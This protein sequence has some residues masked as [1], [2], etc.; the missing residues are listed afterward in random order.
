MHADFYL[1]VPST[2]NNDVHYISSDVMG[3]WDFPKQNVWVVDEG[4]IQ[5]LG[6]FSSF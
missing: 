1:E 6:S 3:C 2:I 4:H 5:G